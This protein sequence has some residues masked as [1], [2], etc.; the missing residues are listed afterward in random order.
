M[1]PILF[2]WDQS[3]QTSYISHYNRACRLNGSLREWQLLLS[4]GSPPLEEPTS[5]ILYE[6][7][8]HAVVLPSRPAVLPPQNVA[9]RR[10]PFGLPRGKTVFSASTCSPVR[11]SLFLLAHPVSFQYFPLNISPLEAELL[12]LSLKS[13]LLA[14]RSPSGFFFIFRHS[15]DYEVFP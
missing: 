10:T 2:F 11:C 14:A 6:L 12:F 1:R 4:P 3:R 15:S 9:R 5:G 7:L 13:P 8:V